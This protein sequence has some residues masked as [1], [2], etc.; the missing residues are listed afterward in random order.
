MIV[1]L[2][3]KP[4]NISIGFCKLAARYYTFNSKLKEK[5]PIISEFLK[6]MKRYELIERQFIPEKEFYNKWKT[7]ANAKPTVILC[8]QKC[9]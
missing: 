3:S 2:N 8:E 6:E 4:E 5:N 7:V 1:G 9:L